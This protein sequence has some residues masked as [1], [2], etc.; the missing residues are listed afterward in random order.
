VLESD[1]LLLR[2]LIDLDQGRT[3]AAAFQAASAM[4]LL[5]RELESQPPTH[6]ID[7]DSLA[8]RARRTEELAD[9]AAAGPLDG[10]QVRELES[11]IDT[12]ESQ[13]DTWRYRTHPPAE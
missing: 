13:L 9:A 6:P 5:P 1:D 4:R 10:D 3:R 12:V 8:E 7:R 2:A 11:I